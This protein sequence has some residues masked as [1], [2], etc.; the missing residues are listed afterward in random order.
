MYE[1]KVVRFDAPLGGSY[2]F[3]EGG[4]PSFSGEGTDSEAVSQGA[5]SVS[6]IFLHPQNRVEAEVYT[7]AHFRTV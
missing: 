6:P 1:D 7:S 4:R 3:L 5:V 2:F